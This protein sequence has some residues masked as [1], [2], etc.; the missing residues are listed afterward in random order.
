MLSGTLLATIAYTPEAGP[1]HL[2]EFES[3]TC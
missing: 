3:K 1:Q 2:Q